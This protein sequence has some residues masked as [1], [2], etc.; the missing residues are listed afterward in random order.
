[1]NYKNINRDWKIK[2]KK[3]TKNNFLYKRIVVVN[4]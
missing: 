3:N 1:M 2:I 4:L